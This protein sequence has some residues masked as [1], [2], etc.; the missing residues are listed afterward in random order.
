[1]AAFLLCRPP[2][3]WAGEAGKMV[4]GGSEAYERGD[5]EKALKSFIDAQLEDPERPEIFYDIGNAYYRLGN[6]DAASE[7][8]RAALK[9][10]DDGLQQKAHYNLGNASYRKGNLEE[11]ITHYEEALRIDPGDEDARK[12]LEFVRRKLEEQRQQEQQEQQERRDGE[13]KQDQ[14]TQDGNNGEG[15]EE[16]EKGQ[17]DEQEGNESSSPGESASPR[18]GSE[19]DDE[20]RRGEEELP[21]PGD[22]DTGQEQQQA[23]GGEKNADDEGQGMQAERILN[24]LHDQPGKAMMP[25]YEK[26]IVEKD[27]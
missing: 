26:R 9:G 6:F 8:Y 16:P 21:Q 10:D 24:R 25:S 15:K 1:M 14:D 22:G 2:V 17:G 12:N 3:V 20:G 23:S 19:M 5:Y 11:A 18:Y 27:W 13:E 4:H 7:N